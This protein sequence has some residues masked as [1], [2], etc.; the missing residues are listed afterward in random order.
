MLL[1]IL[2]VVLFLIIPSVLSAQI[3][4][5]SMGTVGGTT[6][7]AAHEAGNGFD[8]DSYTMDQGGAANPADIR[9]SSGS[10]GYAGASGGANVF[11]TTTSGEYGF[12]I[13]GINTLSC[14]SMTISFGVRKEGASGTA[15]A[16]LVLEYS[17]NS[18]STWTNIPFTAP[19]TASVAGWY[20]ISG[21]AVP[22]GAASS[23][24]WLRW[25][26]TG[27]TSCRLDDIILSGT[28]TTPENCS[29]GLDND[30]DGLIDGA[31]PDCIT[32]TISTGTVTGSPFSITCTSFVPISVPF[33]TSGTYNAG[34]V[35]SVQLSDATGSFSFPI[36]LGN[37]SLSGTAVSGTIPS[38][39]LAGITTGTG[40]RIRV[41]SSDP[42]TTGTDNGVNITINNSG[43]PCYGPLIVNEISQGPSGNKEY[44]EI[45][46]VGNHPCATVDIR[47]L[48]IDDN[49]GDFSGGPVAGTGIANG[50]IRFSSSS[51]WSN[52]PSGSLI[53]IYNNLDVNANLPA[54]DPSDLIVPNKVYVLPVN[55]SFLEGCSSIPTVGNSA[56]TPCTYGVGNYNYISFANSADAAQTRYASGLYNHGVS[57][58]SSPMNGGPD[59]LNVGTTS[60]SGELIEFENTVS[61]DYTDINNFTRSISPTDETPGAPNSAANSIYISSLTCTVLPVELVSIEIKNVDD[62][63][64]LT[65]ETSSEK[66][67]SYYIIERCGIDAEFKVLGRFEGSGTTNFSHRYVFVDENPIKGQSYYRIR[68]YDFN[69]AY[70][71]LPVKPFHLE[72]T[73]LAN[74]YFDG[75]QLVLYGCDEDNRVELYNS[76]G[77]IIGQ[78][79]GMNN[80]DMR[81]F[82]NGYYI[83]KITCTNRVRAVK[84]FKNN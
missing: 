57:W 18:G 38:T 30:G 29:D 32:N 35:F 27:T 47:N 24:L 36:V 14:S 61:D 33:T 62:E 21:V 84:V 49:N 52:V 15:F 3:F 37:L 31:D 40:Y 72:K 39:I 60:S 77:A 2:G 53:V 54:D 73:S 46:V 41:V 10:T 4:T 71:F 58:G 7:I 65:W 28:C 43:S 8:N 26:K 13:K 76:S 81:P 63:A 69:G 19:A 70:Y 23:N 79:S 34:N 51:Q 74:A 56:Y 82:D 66:E 78:F 68:Q 5:E 55:S 9:A 45:L 11:F 50:H 6:S 42:V 44:L 83:V 80:I 1:R 16:T 17:T 12:T 20:L 59:G 75:Q 25:R 22:A 64:V 48:L 67:C